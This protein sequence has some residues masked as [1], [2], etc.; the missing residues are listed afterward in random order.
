MGFEVDASLKSGCS[1]SRD[2][3][4]P[5]CCVVCVCVDFAVWLIIRFCLI[6]STNLSGSGNQNGN[7]LYYKFTFP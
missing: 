1:L 5:E 4:G 7:L 6:E 3:A 2:C